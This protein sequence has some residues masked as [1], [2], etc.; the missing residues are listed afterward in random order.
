M[1]IASAGKTKFKEQG[2]Q[3]VYP[4]KVLDQHVE[5]G[6]KGQ[7]CQLT[8]WRGKGFE[9]FLDARGASKACH[10]SDCE[11]YEAAEGHHY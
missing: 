5:D 1:N 9:D 6:E 8:R 7:C 4:E 10:G 11:T 2:A 3:N